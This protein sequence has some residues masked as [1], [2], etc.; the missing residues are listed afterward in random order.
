MSADLRL[1]I[2]ELADVVARA[3]DEDLGGDPGRDVTTQATIGVDQEAT[4]H[5]VARA[6][7]VVAGLAVWSVVLGQVADRFA[8][9]V[10]TVT[11]RAVAMRWSPD[12]VND[13]CAQP[14]KGS[15]LS[16]RREPLIL[17]SCPSSR[18]RKPVI[19][20]R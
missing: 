6:D 14:E 13:T 15:P 16:R 1:P 11:E 3:L 17:V 12:G 10:P 7:G 5:V 18:P 20:G 4:G 8:L 19:E 2:A 9:P